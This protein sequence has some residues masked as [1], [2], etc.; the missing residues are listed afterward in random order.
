MEKL[1]V[2]IKKSWKI[3]FATLYGIGNV[4]ITV[5]EIITFQFHLYFQEKILK[6][7]SPYN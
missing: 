5:V 3:I 1:L 2:I 4:K 6:I 7:K